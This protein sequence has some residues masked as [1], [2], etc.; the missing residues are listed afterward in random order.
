[1]YQF[2]TS[3]FLFSR[4]RGLL[5]SNSIYALFKFFL[6][7]VLKQLK[8]LLTQIIQMND[9]IENQLFHFFKLSIKNHL[10]VIVHVEAKAR[11]MPE[12]GIVIL[13]N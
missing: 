12:A 4:K 5:L 2:G 6:N 3:S 9:A 7:P 11:G 10:V 13:I 1:M 8:R